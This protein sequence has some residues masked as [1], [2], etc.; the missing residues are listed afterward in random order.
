[1]QGNFGVY[2]SNLK[3]SGM[4]NKYI[5][6]I[7]FENEKNKNVYVYYYRFLSQITKNY[8]PEKRAFLYEQFSRK[9][10]NIV[11]IDYTTIEKIRLN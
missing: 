1:M 8:L 9:K 10:Q 4:K 6:K 2:F 3:K 5:Y 7:T 11:K